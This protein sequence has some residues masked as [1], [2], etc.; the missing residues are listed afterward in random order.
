MERLASMSIDNLFSRIEGY[1]ALYIQTG[2]ER[3]HSYV[4]EAKEEIS[5]RVKARES[6]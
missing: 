5:R 2:D 4:R 1:G 3:F 6:K